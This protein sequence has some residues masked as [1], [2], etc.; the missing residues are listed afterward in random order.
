MQSQLVD[1][2]VVGL[3]CVAEARRA[4]LNRVCDMLSVGFFSSSLDFMGRKGVDRCP[5][6][7]LC[8]G[9]AGQVLSNLTSTSLSWDFDVVGLGGGLSVR[10]CNSFL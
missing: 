3:Q 8:G 1:G 7:W 9:I 5:S 10:I 4:H 6:Q 2:G